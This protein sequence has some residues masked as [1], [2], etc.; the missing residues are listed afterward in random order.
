[1]VF[2]STPVS[3]SMQLRYSSKHQ[4]GASRLFAKCTEKIAKL[5]NA[6]DIHKGGRPSTFLARHSTLSEIDLHLYVI[7]IFNKLET[8][9]E[10]RINTASLCQCLNGPKCALNHLI[11]MAKM[12]TFRCGE[13]KQTALIF[14]MVTLLTSKMVHLTNTFINIC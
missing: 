1:M 12:R 11:A 3:S 8:V 9:F 7:K 6:K 2:D 13:L 5:G 4:L 10:P 14:E